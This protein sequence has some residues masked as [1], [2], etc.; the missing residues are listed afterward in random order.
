MSFGCY[1]YYEHESGCEFCCCGCEPSYGK[2]VHCGCG[3]DHC[4]G[5]DGGLGGWSLIHFDLDPSTNGFPV[6]VQP[7]CPWNSIL[8]HLELLLADSG[9]HWYWNK[10]AWFQRSWL[11]CSPEWS[12]WGSDGTACP[13]LLCRKPL[14]HRGS[15]PSL[16]SCSD[17]QRFAA[18][19]WQLLSAVVDVAAD[20]CDGDNYLPS[21]AHLD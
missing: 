21:A 2:E 6:L 9:E 4:G 8:V 20:L 1:C 10:C 18:Y 13:G 3:Y 5:L 12:A 16:W 11:A 7:S 17:K 19:A 14:H 15:V